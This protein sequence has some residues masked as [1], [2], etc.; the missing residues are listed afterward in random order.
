MLEQP[1]LLLRPWR[2]ALEGQ[3]GT[4]RAW[5]V[6]PVTATPLGFASRRAP[7]SLRWLRWWHRPTVAVHEA[8][9]EPLVF[10]MRAG[11]SWNPS[12][13]VHDAEGRTVGRVWDELLLDRRD[14]PLAQLVPGSE[15]GATIYQG[16]GGQQ[17]ACTGWEDE[18]VRLTFLM[19]RRDNPFVKMLLL[20]AALVHNQARL[21]AS[22]E[23]DQKD[24][25]DQRRG[26]TVL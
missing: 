6:E 18:G 19:H 21:A 1:T 14:E 2:P 17:L 13:R 20:A 10:T 25:K 23:R 12:W 5:I 4:L 15:L 9:D 7:G 16:R 11:W 26:S 3:A 24:P 8:D 22:W